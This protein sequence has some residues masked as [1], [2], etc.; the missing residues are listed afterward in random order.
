MATWISKQSFLCGNTGSASP[1]STYH[2]NLL[3]RDTFSKSDPREVWRPSSGER[4]VGSPRT[5]MRSSVCLLFLFCTPSKHLQCL[6]N[7][8]QHPVQRLYNSAQ[9][10]LDLLH[11]ARVVS[12][13][14]LL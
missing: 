2:R 5:S 3:D 11:R 8:K 14:V 10:C 6:I 13:T 4:R 1:Q 7:N 12:P 9:F